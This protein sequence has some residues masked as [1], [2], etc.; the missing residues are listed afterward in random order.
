MDINARETH[1]V[2][3]SAEGGAT[4]SLHGIHKR[5]GEREVLRDIH[6]DIKPGEFVAIIG[7][8]G[9]GCA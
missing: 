8:S 3:S 4:L 2:A 7:R 1:A 9:C 5:Y 6:L